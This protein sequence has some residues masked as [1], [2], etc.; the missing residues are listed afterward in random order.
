MH[1]RYSRAKTAL[2]APIQ[3]CFITTTNNIISTPTWVLQHEKSD[4][5]KSTYTLLPNFC[6]PKNRRRV[7]EAPENPR[8][9]DSEKHKRNSVCAKM[10]IFPFWFSHMKNSGAFQS[11]S[12]FATSPRRRCCSAVIFRKTQPSKLLK[13]TSKHFHHNIKKNEHVFIKVTSSRCHFR[14]VTFVPP[15]GWPIVEFSPWSRR[16]ASTST[17]SAISSAIACARCRRRRRRS[18]WWGGCCR[19]WSLRRR[20]RGRSRRGRA[21]GCWRRRSRSS[22]KFRS[23]S[24]RWRVVMTMRLWGGSGRGISWRCRRGSRRWR[25]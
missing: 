11:I 2:S 4:H 15:G 9:A 16:G 13:I 14:G 17:R 3:G 25:R 20:S 12:L 24:R 18:R 6:T 5:W 8:A 21:A 1:Y 23:L 22:R 7:G 19:G 10:K